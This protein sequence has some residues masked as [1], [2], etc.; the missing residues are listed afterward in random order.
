[1]EK[2]ISNNLYDK[3]GNN[4]LHICIFYDDINKFYV[5]SLNIF[6]NHKNCKG[7]TPLHLACARGDTIF[8]NLFIHKHNINIH[9]QNNDGNTALDIAISFK[10][11]EIII[12]LVK[13]F[14]I[15]EQNIFNE[16]MRKLTNFFNDEELK[17]MSSI[18]TE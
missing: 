8:V 4:I 3:N 18:F 15:D 6:N 14:Y 5:S 12:I 13:Y 11:K 17:F 16:K 9:E 1:L 2:I 7:N 10:Y